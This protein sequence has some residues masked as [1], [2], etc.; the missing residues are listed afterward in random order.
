MYLAVE[1]K[2]CFIFIYIIKFLFK[3]C[4]KLR[5]KLVTCKAK[6]KKCYADH[7]SCSASMLCSINS[8]EGRCVITRSADTS[9]KMLCMVL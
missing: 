2:A 9:C 5:I 6:L 1:R 3:T 7:S 4:I 8:K